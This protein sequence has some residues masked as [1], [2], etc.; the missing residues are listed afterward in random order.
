MAADSLIVIFSE[1]FTN[2]RSSPKASQGLLSCQVAYL[3]SLKTSEAT[4]P[5]SCCDQT[6]INILFMLRRHLL[7]QECSH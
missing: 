5:P 3:C 2:I 6:G 4:P 1:T 7:S